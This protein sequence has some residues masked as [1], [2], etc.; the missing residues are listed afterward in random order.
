MRIVTGTL[1]A[2][3]ALVCAQN[4]TGSSSPQS[5]PAAA[6]GA[7]S[8]QPRPGVPGLAFIR[9]NYTKYDYRIPMRD[10]AKLF[11]SVYIP[12]DVFTD[13]RTYPIMMERT[14]YNI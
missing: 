7:V 6:P 1:L 12:K 2:I 14:P 11:T 5:A 13:G 3:A 9:E 10:G 8:P 4:R